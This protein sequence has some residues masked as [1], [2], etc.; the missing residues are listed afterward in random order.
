MTVCTV[1]STVQYSKYS[2]YVRTLTFSLLTYSLLTYGMDT[3]VAQ[4]QTV[5]RREEGG[6]EWEKTGYSIR[7]VVRTII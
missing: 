7:Y 4:V 5:I 1:V 6:G 3:V 2:T